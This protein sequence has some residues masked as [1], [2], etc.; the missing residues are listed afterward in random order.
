MTAEDLC[1][2][3]TRTAGVIFST[4]S[5]GRDTTT[6]MYRLVSLI[7]GSFWRNLAELTLT[8]WPKNSDSFMT[9]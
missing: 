8:C 3:N 1:L 7:L 5:V 2:P 4:S 6:D 9:L